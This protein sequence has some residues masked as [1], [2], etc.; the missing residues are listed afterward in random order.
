MKRAVIIFIV[1][2]FL[3]AF[4]GAGY[5]YLMPKISETVSGEND[6]VYVSK[7]KYIAAGSQVNRYSGVI[8]TQELVK[9]DS[10][11]EKKIKT[12]FVKEGDQVKAG[13]KLFDYDVDEMQLEIDQNKLDI[14]EYETEIKGYKEQI[15]SL[16]K[17]KKSV[18]NNKQLSLTNQI[19]KAKLDLQK[20]EY[21]K[22]SLEKDNTKLENSIKNSIVTSSSTGTVQS[23]NDP[24]AGSYITIASNGD[25][26]IKTMV[27]EENIGE[28]SE[29]QDM[30]I[31]SRVSEDLTWR[32]KVTSIDTSKPTS[33]SEEYGG[34]TTTKYPV[35]VSIE[36]SEGLMVGQ[37]VTVEI[38]DGLSEEVKEGVWLYQFY[39]MDLDSD[40]YVWAETPEHTIEKRHVTIGETDETTMQ[41]EIKS[42]LTEEDYVA[43][44]QGRVAEGMKTTY[45]A[46]DI[47]YTQMDGMS[48]EMGEMGEFAEEMPE[49]TAAD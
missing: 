39:I 21:R 4:G 19:E 16:E 10:D 42:G 17:E 15:E 48:G 12:T 30:I 9:I 25:Y 37:H 29:G 26:R 28:F 46:L 27:S 44:P 2:V 40:P 45:N 41:C 24:T 34:T 31:R 49:M 32:G 33:G 13:D 7:I 1:L 36:S 14:A 47:D 5:Y 20:T 18:S 11:A 38:D 3:F 22:Q 35:Y 6:V 43:F 8:E 23:V